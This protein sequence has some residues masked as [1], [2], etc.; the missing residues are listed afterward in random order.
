M[1]VLFVVSILA[2]VPATFVVRVVLRRVVAMLGS[3]V[4]KRRRLAIASLVAP[5]HALVLAGA[6]HAVVLAN[7]ADTAISS[8]LALVALGFLALRVGGIA[9]FDW[10][11]DRIQGIV[12]PSALRVFLNGALVVGVTFAVLHHV[13][14]M[15]VFDLAVIAL[16]LALVA[17]LFFQGL[18]R[19][20]STGI[21]VWLQGGIEVG[22]SVRVQD[23]EGEVVAVNWKSTVLRVSDGGILSVPNQL[24]ASSPFVRWPG[25]G[26]AVRIE[27]PMSVPASSP[28]NRVLEVARDTAKRTTGVLAG[29][30]PDATYEGERD[31]LGKYTV[32]AWVAGRSK[33][34]EVHTRLAAQLWYRLRR[35]GLVDESGKAPVAVRSVL[36]GIPFLAAA[37]ESTLE[38]LAAR[39]SIARYGRGEVLFSQGDHGESLFVIVRGR[40]AIRMNKN[41]QDVLLGHQGAG[42]FIGERSLLTGDPRTATAIAEDDTE[43][44]IIGADALMPAVRADPAVAER[45]SAEMAKRDASRAKTTTN[46]GEAPRE[47]LLSRMRAFFGLG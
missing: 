22:T 42:D 45:I 43:A 17:W 15:A 14:G 30:E 38:Q 32:H 11:L 34:D 27:I 36:Q 16:I 5:L 25:D 7:H 4:S 39:A 2:A 21:S 29:P 31:G 44:I 28:P 26:S 9:V 12:L 3:R 6:V 24:F 10:Y 37:G 35:E 20:F 33:R 19:D 23:F 41:G 13:V 8:G 18:M 47:T 40:V 46:S 1:S